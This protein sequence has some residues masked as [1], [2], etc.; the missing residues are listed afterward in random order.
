MVFSDGR[1]RNFNAVVIHE[2]EAFIKEL[3][4]VGH[5]C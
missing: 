1:R 4:L 3:Y 2:K 5:N